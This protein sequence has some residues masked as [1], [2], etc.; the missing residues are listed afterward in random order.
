YGP[1]P[2]TA[3]THSVF[4]ILLALSVPDLTGESL[5]LSVL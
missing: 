5:V 4:E 1:L 2:L 3:E